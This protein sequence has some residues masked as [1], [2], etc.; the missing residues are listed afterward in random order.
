MSELARLQ[1]LFERVADLEPAARAAVLDAE[2]ADDPV[3][4]AKLESLLASDEALA[5]HTARKAVEQLDGLLLGS[6][7]ESLV[8]AQVG[9]YTLIKPLGAGGMGAV[10]LAE[11]SDGVVQQRVAIKFLARDLLA[12]GFRERFAIERQVLAQL[13]HPAITR[14]ID[15]DQLADGTPYY[16]M[17]YVE[18]KP[19]TR[20]VREQQLDLRARVGLIIE[21]AKAVSHAHQALIVHRDLKPGNILVDAQGQPRLLDFGIAKPL[22]GQLAGQAVSQTITGQRF[23]SPQ[24]AAPE[25]L[26]GEAITV[27]CDVYGIG[28][29]LYELLSGAPAVDLKGLSAAEAETKI[30]HQ[31]PEAP[32][33]RLARRDSEGDPPRAWSGQLKGE[34]DAI[35]LTCLRKAP[36]ERYRSVD[37]L[38]ADLQAWLDGRPVQARGGHGWY[39]ARKFIGRHRWAV[40]AASA[41]AIALLTSSVITYLQSIEAKAQRDAAQAA[42]AEAEQQRDRAQRVTG[43]LIDAFAAANPGGELGKD[44]KAREILERGAKQLETDLADQPELKAQLLATIAEAQ[45]GLSMV[46]EALVTAQSAVEFGKQGGTERGCFVWRKAMARALLADKNLDESVAALDALEQCVTTPQE[47]LDLVLLRCSY[48][49]KRNGGPEMLAYAQAHLQELGKIE[50]QLSQ[51]GLLRLRAYVAGLL[52]GELRLEEAMAEV[53][54]MTE[55]MAGGAEIAIPD[56]LSALSTIAL[57]YETSGEL[58]A[59]LQAAERRSALSL[60]YYGQRSSQYSASLARLASLMGLMGRLSERVEAN[61]KALEIAAEIYDQ[62]SLALYTYRY[63]LALSQLDAGLLDEAEQ[64]V[65]SLFDEASRTL[66]PKTFPVFLYRKLFASVKHA[67][68]DCVGAKRFDEETLRIFQEVDQFVASPRFV[69]IK[70]RIQGYNCS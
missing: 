5:G 36:G 49:G 62:D 7:P 44:V 23:F 52:H 10:Y 58:D 12:E 66:D 59:S 60:T 37:D 32:S 16:V 19:L 40:G 53:S 39:R 20:Y 50:G 2:C 3:L 17:E 38:I 31:L 34:L 4:R 46:R 70:D 6:E 22:A 28:T 57:V 33:Q 26:L 9:R 13:D 15:A 69:E 51:S 18:G 43:F 27:G 1:Q 21:V 67:R 54:R 41:A 64:S 55:M 25:Q 61:R 56:A 65:G 68:G 48:Y 24:H 14:L 45:L 35:T 42:L 29:L 11:R 8:G 47:K 30:L 63:N